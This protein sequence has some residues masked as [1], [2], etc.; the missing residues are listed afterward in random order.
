MINLSSKIS[1][2][3]LSTYLFFINILVR[4]GCLIITQGW[5]E[6]KPSLKIRLVNKALLFWYW[7]FSSNKTFLFFKIESCNI[8]NLFEKEFRESSQNLNSIR[9]LIEKNGSKKC[10]NELNWSKFYEVSQFFFKQMLKVSVF[11]LQKQK[12]FGGRGSTGL[13]A[14]PTVQIHICHPVM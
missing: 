6:P 13:D 7:H 1:K 5:P 3:T 10:L 11:Y 14:T 4:L 2:E 12:S 9:Q 8:Q